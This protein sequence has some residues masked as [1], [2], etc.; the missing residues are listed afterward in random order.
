MTDA[1]YDKEAC[2]SAVVSATPLQ[3]SANTAREASDYTNGMKL[4]SLYRETINEIDSLVTVYYNR[5]PTGTILLDDRTIFYGD[6]SQYYLSYDKIWIEASNNKVYV[7]TPKQENDKPS[8]YKL[9]LNQQEGTSIKPQ[10]VY[11]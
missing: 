10:K 6:N 11:R 7:K 9:F 2:D 5:L 8:C 1:I 3:D 4:K